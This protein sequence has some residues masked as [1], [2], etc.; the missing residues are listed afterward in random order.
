[1]IPRV[2]IRE[3]LS[4]P[5]LLGDVLSGASWKPWRT[6]LIAAMGES[7]DDEERTIFKQL[8]GRDHEPGQT[9]EQ[10]ACVIG[11]RGGKSSATAT[12]VTYLSGLCD[13]PALVRGEKGVI[14]CISLDQR[15]ALIV[16]DYVEAAFQASP[17]L[18]QL[19]EQ[20]TQW[21]LRLKNNLIVEVRAADYR[22]LRGPT[23]V[24]VVADEV[25]FWQTGETSANPD[26]EII[27]AVEPG[28]LTTDG[29]LIM[30]SSPYSRRGVLWQT[31]DRHYGPNG[32]PLILVAQAASKVMNSTLSRSVIS[33]A[34]E[35]DPA[36]ASAEYG[37][38]F[39]SDLQAYISIE[40]VR[41]CITHGVFERPK[42][43]QVAYSGFVD[44]SGGSSDS[45]TL[46]IAHYE[47]S[48]QN[49]V[50]DLIREYTPPF[51][52]SDIC[53]EIAT[54]LRRFGLASATGDKFG[55][56]WVVEQFR[57][58]GI[59]YEPTAEPKSQLYATLLS[60]INS[61][62]VDLLD[63]SKLVAQLT[64][65]ERRTS[66]TGRADTI[67]HPPGGHDDVSNAVA[68]V[69]ATL[70]INTD[71]AYAAMDWVGTPNGDAN[72]DWQRLRNNLYIASGGT[73]VL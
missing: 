32:D 16:L 42:Q 28:L 48:K 8:T 7:L 60:A 11:R 71:A 9:I 33:R 39:R 56:E 61:K 35:K 58:A 64:S 19:I 12:L 57:N 36:R 72:F 41:Q 31:Y 26:D 44:P 5:A 70:L 53:A 73:W 17:I 22:S 30:I 69:V 67:D 15:G 66:R 1:V 6:L 34:F 23:Y 46:S 14:L 49:V 38:Q 45:M 27:S 40:A 55:G 20:R 3:A 24:A 37:A 62:R 52:P 54:E 43:Y 50:I 13:H 10:I 18:S 2:S 29:P 68:G 25:A 4:D 47:L 63:H 59:T 51:A 65:L 21:T